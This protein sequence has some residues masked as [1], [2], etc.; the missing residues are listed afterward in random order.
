MELAGEVWLKNKIIFTK[1]FFPSLFLVRTHFTHP[2]S[3]SSEHKHRSGRAMRRIW[4]DFLDGEK[5]SHTF[6]LSCSLSAK[7]LHE[8]NSMLSI[9]VEMRERK[10]ESKVGIL[11]ASS[12]KMR[13]LSL[14]S[15][16]VGAL[17]HFL[18]AYQTSH[19]HHFAII[20]DDTTSWHFS[21]VSFPL[22]LLLSP[23]TP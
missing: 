16:D 7:I 1:F 22:S 20:I 5:S 9:F 17:S 18:S 19:R 11:I 15:Y 13:V 6:P 3:S 10:R 23:L 4:E 12:M 2:E 21:S 14:E 8:E